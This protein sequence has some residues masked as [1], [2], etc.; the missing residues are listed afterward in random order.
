MHHRCLIC[1]GS[2]TDYEKSFEIARQELQAYFPTIRFSKGEFTTPY[3]LENQNLFY[4]Q[5]AQFETSLPAE[6]VEMLLKGIEHTCGRSIDDRENICM[7]ID[8]LRYD[9]EVLRED[10]Y[11]RS[12]VQNGIK[13][14]KE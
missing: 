6:E 13:E 14:L 8:L 5:I 10:D 11:E 1:C 7:D 9:K 12:Y 4:N 3:N 2:N